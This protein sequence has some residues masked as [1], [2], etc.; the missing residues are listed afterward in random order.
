MTKTELARELVTRGLVKETEVEPMN[1][2]FEI[3]ETAYDEQKSVILH[4]LL[5]P[6]GKPYGKTISEALNETFEEYGI[7]TDLNTAIFLAQDYPNL[8]EWLEALHRDFLHRSWKF[9]HSTDTTELTAKELKRHE[10]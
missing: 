4:F 6:D 7:P 10:P 8:T 1:E 9:L 3:H 2:Y 5:F